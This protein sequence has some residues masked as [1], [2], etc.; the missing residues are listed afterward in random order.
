MK[1]NR[2]GILLVLTGPS[3]V[4]KGTVVQEV[5]KRGTPI[6]YSISATTRTPRAG[7]TDGVDY[8]FVTKELFE[9]MLQ[10]DELLEHADYIQN[11]Y[12]TPA[13]P[14]LQRLEEGGDVL[15]EI[16]VRGAMQIRNSCPEAVLVFLAPPSMEILEQRLRGRGTESA[17]LLEKRLK[18]ARS[19]CE[20]AASFDYIVYNEHFEKATDDLLSIL[21][22]EKCRTA[23]RLPLLK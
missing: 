15:L 8:H 13:A 3:G 4:G 7:E 1:S 23:R 14:V 11:S 10:R 6:Y 2:R 21:T 22:A 17:E 12:G 9:E 19:E 18:K 5:R 20:T 16:E